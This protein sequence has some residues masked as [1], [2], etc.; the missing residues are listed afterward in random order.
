MGVSMLGGVRERAGVV[1]RDRRTGVLVVVAAGWG[2]SIGV[3]LIYP[4]LLPHLRAWYGF[5][6]TTA[7]L[8]LAVLWVVYALGQLP[9]GL[10]ADRFGERRVL[11]ISLVLSAGFLAF[12]VTA[13][14]VV[15]LFGA[16][17]C[18]ALA[19]AL[20][21]VPRVTVLVHLYPDRMGSAIGV[22]MAAGD[23]GNTVLPPIAAV[24]AAV[25]MW[26]VGFGVW[27]P[28]LLI[29]GVVVWRTVPT[30]ETP[31]RASVFSVGTLRALGAEL[32]RRT[33]A[34]VLVIVI[35]AE[36]TW[37]AFTSFYPTYLVEIKGFSPTLAAGLFGLF[38]ACGSVVKLLAGG[39]YDRVGIRGSLPLILGIAAGALV[40]LPLVER[41]WVIVLVTV[42]ISSFLGAYT[43]TLTYLTASLSEEIQGAGLGLLRTIYIMLGAGS[44][45]VIGALADRGLFDEAFW[46]IAA[47][48]TAA[49]LLTLVLP[50]TRRDG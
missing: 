4:A 20:Y 19:A 31:R 25:A 2:L 21:A 22:S 23:V 13:P 32:R 50:D 18:F 30:V 34:Q 36:I 8:L 44:P 10:L 35:L 26:Q 3:R 28:V 43:V 6:L 5:D 29:A 15:V 47:I 48:L 49:I 7:G 45:I 33:I 11:G 24:L 39:A 17:A 38:F 12:V 42:L 40:V 1:R 37:H 16:T 9:G 41:V 14:S 46:L 27:I